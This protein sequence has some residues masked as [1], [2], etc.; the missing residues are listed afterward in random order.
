MSERAKSLLDFL[1]TP[2]LVGDPDGRTVYVN[3]AFE[4]DFLASAE[5]VAGQP[6]A[7]L[8]TGGGR[9]AVLRA[10]ARV[11]GEQSVSS[12]ERFGVFVEERGYKALASAVEAEEGRVGVILLLMRESAGEARM[13]SLGREILAPLDELSASLS[14]LAEHATTPVARIALADAVRCLERV[15]KWSETVA[16][17]VKGA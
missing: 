5:S 4:T 14:N 6:I 7:N 12:V 3:P 10:V 11:C 15:R 2:V 17:S 9:E 8:F 16:A 13:Q 1:Q